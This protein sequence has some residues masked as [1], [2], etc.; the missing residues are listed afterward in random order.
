MEYIYTVWLRDLAVTEDDPDYEW[1]A[2]FIVKGN[3]EQS[4]KGWGD[5]LAEKY[6]KTTKNIILKSMIE[7][8]D[9]SMLT[10]LESLPIIQEF[11]EDSDGKIGW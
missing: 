2:C 8:K 5:Y 6:V 1:P 11:E 10:G 7:S 9:K 3:S 4:C